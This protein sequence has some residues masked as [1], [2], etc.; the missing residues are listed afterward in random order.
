MPMRS[1]RIPCGLVALLLPGRLCAAT[2]APATP[3]ATLLAASAPLTATRMAASVPVATTL[4][5]PS[6]PVTATLAAAAVSATALATS[7]PVSASPLAGST[8]PGKSGSAFVPIVDADIRGA[9][10]RVRHGG[11]GHGGAVGSILVLPGWRIT[12][13]SI[14]LP[15]YSFEGSLYN[16]V[17]EEDILYLSRQ[18]HAGSLGFKQALGPVDGRISVDADYALT[19]ESRGEKLGDGLYDYRDFGGRLGFSWRDTGLGVGARMYRRMYVHFF[20]LL[21]SNSA[22]VQGL[23]GDTAGANKGSRPKDYDGL[24][25]NLSWSGKGIEALRVKAG[26]SVGLRAYRD[27]YIWTTTRG[28]SDTKRSDMLHRVTGG[29]ALDLGPVAVGVDLEGIVNLSNDM[30]KVSPQQDNPGHDFLAHYYEFW[31]ASFAPSAI[32][33]LS[34]GH[35]LHPRVRLGLEVTTRNYPSRLAQHQDGQYADSLQ[36]DA[37]YAADLGG[38]VPVRKWL[39]VTGN[40]EYRAVRSNTDYRQLLQPG[41]NLL[42]ASLGVHFSY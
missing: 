14:L 26:Y 34:F 24:E 35:D 17:V 29:S 6:V 22:Q 23:G 20:S 25:G 27:K 31:S 13:G 28:I 40:V 18:V 42:T 37:E 3:T 30:E 33:T 12:P 21:S 4:L 10:G 2:A 39:Q 15:I 38:M 8:A 41:Y 32:W 36:H 19:K 1:L 16:H 7:P 9:F 11:P 5:S